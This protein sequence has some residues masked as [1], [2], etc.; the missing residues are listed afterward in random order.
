[1]PSFLLKSVKLSMGVVLCMGHVALASTASAPLVYLLLP[2]VGLL[3]MPYGEHLNQKYVVYQYL[4][5][6]VTLLFVCLMPFV[7]TAFGLLVMGEVLI[8]FIV[9]YKLVHLK[10]TRDY[11]TLLLMS[12][13]LLVSACSKAPEAS[14]GLILL[15]FLMSTV[16]LLVSL[17]SHSEAEKAGANL[18]VIDS[19]RP[20]VNMV[21]TCA[22]L[23]VFCVLFTTLL[24][25]VV[26]RMEAGMLSRQQS[27][28]G[29]AGLR[30]NVDLTLTGGIATNPGVAMSAKLPGVV[31]PGEIAESLYWRTTSY[32][33]FSGKGWA[34]FPATH[35]Y[36]DGSPRIDYKQDPR[37]GAV[38]SEPVPQGK[39]VRQLI[40]LNVVPDEG[41]PVLPVVVHASSPD[42]AL[43]W[44]EMTN[45]YAV[46]PADEV[47]TLDYEAV[48]V[49]STPNP[50]ALRRTRV[51]DYPHMIN[52][53]DFA[54]LT[55]I[56]GIEKR[57]EAYAKQITLGF[58]NSYDMTLAI[59]NKLRDG[60]FLYSRAGRPDAEALDPIESFLFESRTGHCELFASTMVVLLR[61]LLIPS[62]VV[63]GYR[64]GEWDPETQSIVVTGDRAHLWVEVF[65]PG[66]G[67]LTF[68][69]SPPL[70]FDADQNTNLMAMLRRSMLRL[71]L[72]WFNNVVNYKGLYGW[73]QLRE[74]VAAIFSK[75]SVAPP[76]G[77]E[78]NGSSPAFQTFSFSVVFMT[79]SMV[80]SVMA[81]IFVLIWGRNWLLIRKGTRHL[82]ASQARAVILFGKLKR[83]L[84]RFGTVVDGKSAGEILTVSRKE[85]P[86]D[87][88][89][90]MEVLDTYD[91]VR[92]G[93]RP[94]PRA[95]ARDLNRKI[96]MLR[97]RKD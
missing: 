59:Q 89:V 76:Q 33:H 64:G 11:Y 48:S 78:G 25:F 21:W 17:Q 7:F 49:I 58:N 63:S 53:N 61:S 57:V 93:G 12:F 96:Q 14:I 67:W 37:T 46:F 94:L 75:E 85:F 74:T 62:R 39:R 73:E 18:A 38:F 60:D 35:F 65:F 86:G 44:N 91:A 87:M 28:A 47:T 29:L 27:F 20:A 19:T 83:R 34:R 95:C 24:F 54:Q 32:E 30:E 70:D 77:S 97:P 36:T 72:F 51:A 40:H 66:Q 41:L 8:L 80:L 23:G 10:T 3:A 9:F 84:K 1:M 42:T 71:K 79:L 92:F 69:P 82:D 26:P 55:L 4:M 52:S 5:N 45:D 2:V 88:A 90:V 6:A 50:E 43:R 15:L 81:F 13:F 68:D 16:W 31:N 22:R 56:P